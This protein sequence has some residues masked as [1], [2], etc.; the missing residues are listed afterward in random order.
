MAFNINAQV[1][2]SGPKNIRAVT[3][4]IQQQ[5]GNINANVNLNIPKGAQQQLT[6]L[7][8]AT[9]NLANN[10]SKLNNTAQTAAKSVANV[11]KSTKQAASA[12]QVLGKETALTFKRF[13]AAG[14]V[15]GTVFR[16]TQAISEG[17]GKALEFERGLV[18]LQQITGKTNSQLSGLKRTVNDLAQSLGQDANEILEIGQIF[19][20]TGQSIR[21]I[22]ASI[23]AVS[24]S[25]LAPT[26]GEMKQTA[27]GL[28]AALNQFG[29]SASQS[30]AIL[31][32]LNRVSKKFAVESDDLIAAIRRAGGVFAISAGEIEKPIDA[33]NQFVGIFTAVRSTTRESAETVATG[34]RTIFSRI[35]RRGTIDTLKQLGINLTDANGKFIGLFQSF[36]V[37][38]TELDKIVQKGDAVTLSAITEELGG[39][40]QIGKLIPAIRNFRKAEAAFAEAQ[41]GAIQGLG[42]DVE[43][44]LTPLIKT[45]EQVSAR[46]QNLIRTISE[47]ATFQSLAKTAAGLA[48]AFLSVSETLTPLLPLILKF[49]TI[50]IGRSAAGFL[51]G[52]TS[53]FGGAGA[54]GVGQTVG[55]ALS[56]GG[57][58]GA[59]AQASA[60]SS[61]SAASAKLAQATLANTTQLQQNTKALIANN[62]ALNQLVRRINV[63]GIGFGGAGRRRGGAR[64]PRG[65]NRGGLVP[66]S[67]NSDTV[68][69]MLTPGEFVIRK[70]ATQAFGAGN[71]A[72]INKYATGGVV[73]S[74]TPEFTMGV[75]NGL[76]SAPRRFNT[77][78]A[79]VRSI[80]NEGGIARAELE[81]AFRRDTNIVGLGID[82]EIRLLQKQQ[83]NVNPLGG[84]GKQAV[85]RRSRIASQLK[86]RGNKTKLSNFKTRDEV[87]AFLGT[88]DV[89]TQAGQQAG[90]NSLLEGASLIA[91]RAFA[92]G[93]N[94]KFRDVF[95]DILQDGL[96][97]LLSTS[98]GQ[99]GKELA[100]LPKPLNAI[101]DNSA[102]GSV[103]GQLF[104]GF[105]RLATQNFIA[106]GA[107]DKVSG[108]FDVL[109]GEGDLNRYRALFTGF[110]FPGEIKN[111]FSESNIAST[112]GKAVKNFKSEAIKFNPAAVEK[113]SKFA[114]GGMASG[115][116]TVP[117]LLTPG[118]F[119]V[120]KKSAQAIGYGNLKNINK[121]A[122]GGVV[123]R[124]KNG[125]NVQGGGLSNAAFLLPDLL[126]TVPLLVES[127]KQAADGVEGAGTQLVSALGSM[128]LSLF[129]V[130]KEI[131]G[132]LLGGLKNLRGSGFGRGGLIGASRRG[133]ERRAALGS[134][135][136]ARIAKIQASRVGGALTPK[137]QKSLDILKQRRAGIAG[138]GRITPKALGLAAI[139]PAIVGA[140]GFSLAEPLSK[141]F[142]GFSGQIEEIQ[143]VSGSRTESAAAAARR[144]GV[145]GG[146]KGASSLGAIGF[147]LGGP[148]GAAIGAAVGGVIGAFEGGVRA[149]AEKLRFDSLVKLTDTS[150][151]ATKAM[152]KL[153]NDTNLTA[154]EIAA[155]TEEA[156]RLT[157][158]FDT[159]IN[160]FAQARELEAGTVTGRIGGFFSGVGGGISDFF[161]RLGG[162]SASDLAAEDRAEE[163][164]VIGEKVSK[165][166]SVFTKEV[167]DAFTRGFENIFSQL[168][169]EI[170]LGEEGVE[171]K[172]AKFNQIISSIDTETAAD[173]ISSLFAVQEVL[174]S[175]GERGKKAADQLRK[176]VQVR[177][178]EQLDSVSESLGE[179][180]GRFKAI[181]AQNFT[182]DAFKS[183]EALQ[184]ARINALREIDSLTGQLGPQAKQTFNQIIQG[185]IGA[186]LASSSAAAAQA[187]YNELMK[188]ATK[189]MD[190]V[191]A[192]VSKLE[193]VF[194]QFSSSLDILVSNAQS[195]VDALIS[196]EGR[197]ELD[198]Q[199]NPFENLDLLGSSQDFANTIQTALDAIAVSGGP[200]AAQAVQGLGGVPQFAANIESFTKEALRSLDQARAEGGG[201][202]LTESDARKVL[203][204]VVPEE[205]RGTN[206]ADA[207]VN[208]VLA[209]GTK[210]REGGFD[211]NFEAVREA[212]QNEGDIRNK[213]AEVFQNVTES[214]SKIFEE[215]QKIANKYL[216]IGKIQRQVEKELSAID[217]KKLDIEKTVGEI[218]GE[219]TGTLAEAEADLG[220]RVSS[221][222]GGAVGGTDAATLVARQNQ[223]RSQIESRR[224]EVV[225]RNAVGLTSPELL[226]EISS[227]ENQL[228]G[229]TDAMKLLV[230][231]TE[232]LSAV[233]SEIANLEKRQGES[234]QGLVGLLGDLGKVQAQ[235]REA[236]T[237]EDFK[238]A[239]EE[240]KRVRERFAVVQKLQQGA[241]LN[242]AEAAEVL[243][244]RFDQ[245]LIDLGQ[246]PAALKKAINDGF[247][248]ARGAAA[249]ALEQV[250]V[251]L[252]PDAFKDVNLGGEIEQRKQDARD[253]AAQK[254]LVLDANRN[255]L[256]QNTNEILARMEGKLQE[257]INN[258]GGGAAAAGAL[259]GDNNVIEN[260][261]RA[262]VGL[263]PVGAPNDFRP[264][265]GL[266]PAGA[267]L[268]LRDP[269]HGDIAI[270]AEDV[271]AMEEV[272]GDGNGGG[273]QNIE[274]GKVRKSSAAINRGEQI[275]AL[276]GGNVNRFETLKEEQKALEEKQAAES[277]AFLEQQ[278]NQ[279]ELQKFHAE[280][281]KE[282][283]EKAS[284]AEDEASRARGK[285]KS[286]DSENRAIMR[287]QDLGS[288]MKEKGATSIENLKQI[289][290]SEGLSRDEA[291]AFVKRRQRPGTGEG[292]R[293]LVEDVR[294][295]EEQASNAASVLRL[296]EKAALDARLTPDEL[297]AD[298]IKR[299]QDA[300]RKAKLDASPSAQQF[301]ADRLAL[302][303]IDPTISAFDPL[304]YDNEALNA[305]FGRPAD[306]IPYVEPIRK[307]PT[308][309][310]L[311]NEAKEI[312]RVRGTGERPDRP[313]M[314]ARSKARYKTFAG[315]GVGFGIRQGDSD[316]FGGKTEDQRLMAGMSEEIERRRQAKIAADK[317]AA[318]ED[319]RRRREAAIAAGKGP[320]GTGPKARGN[321]FVPSPTLDER[322]NRLEQ[323][324]TTGQARSGFAGLL[325]AGSNAASTQK[326]RGVLSNINQQIAKIEAARERGGGT[327]DPKV[328]ARLDL[329][330]QRR[331]GLMGI[332]GVGYAPD[333]VAGGGAAGAGGGAAGAGGGAAVG[334]G[335][336]TP[337]QAAAIK[338]GGG[339][340][341][342]AIK[343]AI[344]IAN[345]HI[346]YGGPTGTNDDFLNAVG[347]SPASAISALTGGGPAAPD[348]KYPSRGDLGL[349]RD[350]NAPQNSGR[351]GANFAPVVAGG[352]PAGGGGVAGPDVAMQ[353]LANALNGIR[354]GINLNIGE[355]NV[356]ITNTGELANSIKQAVIDAIGGGVNDNTLASNETSQLNTTATG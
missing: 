340:T 34:L 141:L 199:I 310:L 142:S 213:F 138:L 58:A 214:F 124:F 287:E 311:E 264:N 292:R 81:Q 111:V 191:A 190:A 6:N 95:G 342:G 197:F 71:L 147:L 106:D 185:S 321:A 245:L 123:Q 293:A 128:A 223:I 23:R 154:D 192:A 225:S 212:L 222:T 248:Q 75:L 237:P 304:L 302:L 88:A 262:N 90:I 252:P 255:I 330:K 104:E 134:R 19:A 257:L 84:K 50:K 281:V 324:Q 220:A 136:D 82:D 313:G 283:K 323:Y 41:A 7:G 44:G 135:I 22:Q 76:G 29:I 181:I 242:L 196:G 66:G 110:E 355:V 231:E 247:A 229:N 348:P 24:R 159:S 347:F 289:F 69:A 162:A 8:K 282:A 224:R 120:N 35:Q 266:P 47:S 193:R 291:D 318:E 316:R 171:S 92:T 341:S 298:E 130:S 116:D 334:G 17:V 12:M 354:D 352:A 72:G 246:D 54:R 216:E 260:D 144:G 337:E 137:S 210:G 49:A 187:H 37:L 178:L 61:L 285:L 344:N 265:A 5:L 60:T 195:Q 188:Q 301:V 55:G 177:F 153:A 13:A 114:T 328:Q 338:G 332:Q 351:G 65:F 52:F 80:A 180:S 101:L 278:S 30:E 122:K 169:N 158:A 276:T 200:G 165:S 21:E 62:I 273:F 46:F 263:P 267:P 109:A 326:A 91:P 126:F 27:E 254:N 42:S 102:L 179:N 329:L 103:Q 270:P 189:E 146:I 38:S 18:K 274:P 250:R 51:Q 186:Q 233:Q 143:G 204:G 87:V 64:P 309:L 160:A 198:T 163:L 239:V 176:T 336:I 280:R 83:S 15:T 345:S 164:D 284:L 119:V 74:L 152:E 272:L 113:F 268:I 275:K 343:D 230:D 226:K 221:L 129:F 356:T 127:F 1:I 4:S 339:G 31:G 279:R 9:Q 240:I 145:S 269:L 79:S 33:L 227:L 100:S 107:G 218:T 121:Y 217:F 140:I 349:N 161:R 235:L 350:P 67:G 261:F 207:F 73:G 175:T 183:E 63:G 45:F 184:A 28:V 331:T 39:I 297:R 294:R 290:Q 249:G 105:T 306:D 307:T 308:E 320:Q 59:R 78:G 295:K 228:A 167:A 258:F 208:S 139:G 36:R 25:S 327:L 315:L 299:Q 89:E 325:R 97:L 70:S 99:F 172:L 57:G 125:G 131:Q 14:I 10:T 206:F 156:G 2:L 241:P 243:G 271:A 117:A 93:V 303:N 215:N 16:L 168:V 86:G 236:R 11:G 314:M 108:L 286:F 317:A 53:G 32:S 205:L 40:R 157:D 201:Q 202:I 56:G 312:D 211:F 251:F 170:S 115:T 194:S 209:A 96:P 148:I 253:I 333:P 85:A 26:F 155:A 259:R 353:N 151:V 3:Q 335:G 346:G 305:R 234:R 219:R 43:K 94:P 118:E 174:R 132:G 182:G 98:L 48:N 322:R 256:V 173:S 166:L 68:P 232:R 238:R 277:K 150:L 20:Q 149:Q 296:R 244:G 112:F 133:A 288:L 319:L 203:E 300:E 77:S